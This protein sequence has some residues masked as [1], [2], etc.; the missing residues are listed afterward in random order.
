[1]W[2]VINGMT[3]IIEGNYARPPAFGEG[4]YTC[5]EPQFIQ[6]QRGNYL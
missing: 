2:T 5:P 6:Q 3:S 4:S 1:M